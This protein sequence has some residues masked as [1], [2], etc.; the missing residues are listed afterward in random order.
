MPSTFMSRQ[1][2]WSE[3]KILSH[4]NLVVIVPLVLK[5]TELRHQVLSVLRRLKPIA[6]P[7]EKVSEL[8]NCR[9]AW[10]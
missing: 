2:P 10:S 9:A 7:S 8:P 5:V 4:S 6:L 3:C 1:D